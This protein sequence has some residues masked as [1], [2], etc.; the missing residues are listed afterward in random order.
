MDIDNVF[1]RIGDFGSSQKKI[2]Y[3]LC[4]AQVFLGLHALVLAFIGPETEWTCGEKGLKDLA[5]RCVEFETGRCS[6]EY[7]NDFSSIVSEVQL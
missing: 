5:S 2:F 3:I 1:T 4:P 7:S 6:P